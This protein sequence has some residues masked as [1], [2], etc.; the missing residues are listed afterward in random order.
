M[1]RTKTNGTKTDSSAHLGFEAKLWLSAD[2]ATRVSASRDCAATWRDLRGAQDHRSNTMHAAEYQHVVLGLI[3]L[4]YISDTGGEIRM[5]NDE[6]RIGSTVPTVVVRHSH[7]GIR[8][9]DARWPQLQSRAKLP[10][11][12]KDVDWEM[13]NVECGMSNFESTTSTFEIRMSEELKKRTKKFALDVIA[14]CAGFPQVLETR[15]AIGQI[16][17]SSSSV[18]ANYRSACRGK[19]KADIISKLGTVEEEADES[20]FWLEMLRDIAHLRRLKIEA[21]AS[22]ELTRLLDEANQ[23]VAITVAS[24]K[25]A[26]G[27]E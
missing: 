3:F 8:T 19:S 7:F 24:R 5:S 14:L 15:H 13:T 2:T 22:Q 17:R 12:G 10:S 21:H 11:T 25:T 26:R 20:R 9:S 4:K 23:L 18:A 27:S 1:G 6:C 16:I